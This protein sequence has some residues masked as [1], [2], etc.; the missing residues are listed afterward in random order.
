MQASYDILILGLVT[1]L[2]G[3]AVAALLA[4]RVL[5]RDRHMEPAQ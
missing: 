5:W 1:G 3:L 2:S 4:F